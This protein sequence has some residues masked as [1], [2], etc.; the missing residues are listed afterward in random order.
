M[1]VVISKSTNRLAKLLRKPGGAITVSRAL[2]SAKVNLD[3]IRP[4]CCRTIDRILE[5]MAALFDA[6]KGLE[7]APTLYKLSNQVV[8][9]AGS[10]DMMELSQAAYSLCETLDRMITAERWS[11]PPVQVH[12]AAMSRLRQV[13]GNQDI[14][15]AI[16]DGLKRVA[17]QIALS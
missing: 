12:L 15:K 5:D 17:A 6:G 3:A 13:D 10:M 7:N 11:S 4:E 16:I 14:C 2:N 9:F 8:G 1:S